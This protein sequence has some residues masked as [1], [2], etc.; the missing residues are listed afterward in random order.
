MVAMIFFGLAKCGG[1]TSA[2]C[3][4]KQHFQRKALKL[5]IYDDTTAVELR[6]FA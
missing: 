1:H 6:L 5:F 2:V 3:E 4:R